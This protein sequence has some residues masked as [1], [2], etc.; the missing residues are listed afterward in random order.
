VISSDPDRRH[1]RAIGLGRA[2]R[3]W[4]IGFSIL[5][6]SVSLIYPFGR[7]QGSYS[8]AGWV[9]LEGGMPYLDV[10]AYKPPMNVLLHALAMGV[11][12]VNTWA[13]RAMD[14]A[15]TAATGL[16]VA[17]VAAELWKRRDATLAVGLAVPFFYY[18]IDYWTTAQTDGW[19]TLPCAAAVWAVLRGGRALDRGTRRAVVWWMGA[20][21]LAGAAVL[22]KYTAGLI[23]LPM[24]LALAW[25]RA[26]YLRRVWIGIPATL[27]GGL[28][29][30]GACGAWLWIGGAWDAFVE[31]QLGLA[32]Y[33]GTRADLSDIS[34][35]LKWLFTLTRTK[36]DLV[37]LVWAPFIALVPAL[38]AARPKSRADWVGWGLVMS[39]WLM[40]FANVLAQG[41]FY[42][43]HYLP[44][45][46]PSALVTGL[47]FSALLRLPL[48][49]V[50]QRGFRAAIVAGLIAVAIVVTPLGGRAAELARV[51]VGGQTIEEYVASRSE[52][53][54]SLYNVGEIRDVADLLQET[55]T[56]EQRVFLW[57]YAPTVFVRARRHTVSRFLY[58]FPLRTPWRNQEYRAELMSTLRA[59]PPEVFIVASEDRY[60]GLT[61]S[62]LD[63]AALLREFE[64]LNDFVGSRYALETKIG[65]YS[66][67]RLKRRTG[68]PDL[69]IISIDTLRPDRLGAYGA[70]AAQ[71][72]SIDALA[73]W[74]TTFFNAFVPMGL[75]TPALA[76]M[77]TGLWPHEHGSREVREPILHGEVI[78]EVLRATGYT[79]LGVIANPAAGR[80]LGLENGFETFVQVGDQGPRERWN[81]S[82]VTD[83][84]TALVDAAPS[85]KPFFLW[86]HYLDPHWPYA[87]PGT[88][89]HAATAGCTKLGEEVPRGARESNKGGLAQE[90]LNDCWGAYDEEIAYTDTQVGRL[91]DELQK[92][93]RLDHAVVLFTADHGENFGEGGLYY[94]HGANAHDASLRVPL[95]M[96][97]PGFAEGATRRE[98]VRIIDVAPTLL[99][100]GRVPE[101]SWPAMRGV[102][103]V[104]PSGKEH[105]TPGLLA[106]GESGGSPVLGNHERLLSGHILTGHCI[107]KEEFSLCWNGPSVPRLYDRQRDPKLKQDLRTME[108]VLYEEML[109]ARDRWKPGQTRERSVSDGRFKLIER[110]LFEGGYAR[111]L[112]DT[113]EDWDEVV[114][115]RTRHPEVYAKLAGEL[116]AWTA[117]I[118]DQVP[119]AIGEEAEAQLRELG[120][121]E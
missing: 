40:A 68:P 37:P 26:T 39:W 81:A 63:S 29:T 41:K 95:I 15:W 110:P 93:K 83:H 118:P 61:G 103:Q 9:L 46:A 113:Q 108:P 78:T 85:D 23:G 98:V 30:L 94:T 44:L 35:T 11:F 55:T 5:C 51:T 89:G 71:S 72:P 60:V 105:A 17:S 48:S 112:Y 27:V 121:V 57:G 100:L 54:L 107:N 88:E 18:Q 53:A 62:K 45:L 99:A 67:F 22:F 76:S 52:Y 106:F 36:T 38:I 114:D 12:G 47:G 3:L 4:I 82:D 16:V 21:A 58:N 24:L 116:D 120:Y 50:P 64:E 87:A 79:T 104:G 20:G 92:R 65:R 75:T 119:Q 66:V 28:L 70:P 77:M 49:R 80:G 13:I 42:D 96:A 25:V 90:R 33:I 10:Y 102:S 74:G 6:G 8:Y 34:Q 73:A 115:V 69:I 14:I 31:T 117:A 91:L 19:M 84:A 32:S 56:P 86:A 2:T 109:R 97:G 1:E 43:Y 101:T 7:D 59:E 111:S